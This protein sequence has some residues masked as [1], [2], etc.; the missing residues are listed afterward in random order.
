MNRIPAT[1]KSLFTLSLAALLGC[2]GAAGLDL[3]EDEE[4][5]GGPEE[6]PH[7]RVRRALSRSPRGPRAASH[8]DPRPRPTQV[9]PCRRAL[10]VAFLAASLSACTEQD[11]DTWDAPER[12]AAPTASGS[13]DSGRARALAAPPV[14]DAGTPP[15]PAT[16]ARIDHFCIDR[17]EAHLVARGPG[18]ELR[19]HP[20]F[21]RPEEG[22]TYEARS[23]P[24]ALPQ[25]Y[26]SRIDSQA[27]CVNAGKRL[28]SRKEWQRACKG[29]LGTTYPYGQ[30]RQPGR[31]NTEK[32]HLVTIRF[33][34][35]PGRWTYANFNDPTLGQEPGFLARS[36]EHTGCVGDAGVYDLVG[37]LHE[38]VSD[39][40]TAAFRAQLDSE[41]VSRAF[42][43]WSPGNGVF[44]GGFQSTQGELGP[45]CNFTT[46]AHEPSYHDYSTGFRCCADAL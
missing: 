26:V 3:D 10:L 11:G 22:V 32:P 35:D 46:I 29:A 40:A 16:M 36:G 1:L 25:A 45:G 21:Q 28:C 7:G 15:C 2:D 14:L 42:Q 43:Y 24:G 17:Y 30:R 4:E 6:E 44:M 34:A 23:E 12:P 33:G 8:F 41:G 38:W 20:H 13:G 9:S 18:G 19:P 5:T 39:T 27:A 37:N 31:C